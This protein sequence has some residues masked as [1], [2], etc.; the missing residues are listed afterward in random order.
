MFLY[1]PVKENK[2]KPPLRGGGLKNIVVVRLNSALSASLIIIYCTILYNNI[3]SRKAFFL[4]SH[5]K[6]SLLPFF[7]SSTIPVFKCFKFPSSQFSKGNPVRH[8]QEDSITHSW[9]TTLSCPKGL[10]QDIYSPY[11]HWGT[12]EVSPVLKLISVCHGIFCP[13]GLN[14]WRQSLQKYVLGH[15]FRLH[16]RDNF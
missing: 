11:P 8:A 7:Q 2:I 15:S 13:L 6:C 4:Y 5:P 1:H 16:I 9:H 14:E 3:S 10:T 12:Q